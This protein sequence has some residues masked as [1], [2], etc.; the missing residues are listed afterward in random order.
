MAAGCAIVSSDQGGMPE[1]IQHGK[2]GLLAQNEDAA[3]FIRCLEQLIEDKAMRE[4]LGAAA[5]RTV[6]ESFTDVH[7]ARLSTDYYCE[8]L[9]S[10]G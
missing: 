1:L 7:I 6:E 5:R 3:T 9:N 8:Y 10:R 2:N 4:R